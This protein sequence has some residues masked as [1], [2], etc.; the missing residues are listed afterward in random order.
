MTETFIRSWLRYTLTL[1]IVAL[2][3][4]VRPVPGVHAASITV[5]ATLQSGGRDHRGQHECGER[6]LPRW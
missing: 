2:I 5:N 1:F 6:G 3:L 4:F